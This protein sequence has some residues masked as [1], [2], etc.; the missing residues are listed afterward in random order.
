MTYNLEL[1]TKLRTRLE[2]S[3][4]TNQYPHNYVYTKLNDV[5]LNMQVIQ[6][7]PLSTLQILKVIDE[8]INYYVDHDMPDYTLVLQLFRPRRFTLSR[9][10]MISI[11]DL[12]VKR[13][14]YISPTDFLNYLHYNFNSTLFNIREYDAKR[15]AIG[16]RGYNGRYLSPKKNIRESVT[17]NKLW[18]RLTSLQEVD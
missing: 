12:M 17:G 3:L 18:K 7:K 1:L 13:Y 6:E 5:L 14:G 2:I 16:V 10:K 9:T 15:V 11:K 4:A 8:H